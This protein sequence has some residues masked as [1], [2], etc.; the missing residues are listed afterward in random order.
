MAENVNNWDLRF[1]FNLTK[2]LQLRQHSGKAQSRMRSSAK[3]PLLLSAVIV[4][5]SLLPACQLPA[6]T[7]TTLY[8]FPALVPGTLNPVSGVQTG[9]NTDGAVPYAGLVLSGNTLYGTTGLGGTSSNGTVF[10][11]NTDGTGF[12]N[13]HTFATNYPGPN[14]HSIFGASN[15][16][17]AFPYGGLTL[18][19][20]TLYG[21]A[22]YGGSTGNGVVYKINT[23][24]TGFTNLHSFAGGSG[25]VDPLGGLTV[26]GSVLY[27]TTSEGGTSNGGTVFTLNTNGTGF[28][29]LAGVG[30]GPWATL[31]LSGNV[32]YGTGQIGGTSG[33]GVVFAVTTGGTGLTNLH[34][35]SATSGADSVNGDG[36]YPIAGLILSGNILYGT[37]EFGGKNGYGTVFAIN[38]NGT[39]FTNLHNFTSGSDGSI[40]EAGLLL[41]GGILYGTAS[42]GGMGGRGAIFAVSTNGAGFTTLNSFPAAESPRYT[43]SGGVFPNAGLILSGYTPY[44]TAESGGASGNGTVFSLSFAPQLAVALSG[45]NVILTWPAAFDGFSYAGF[46]LQSAGSLNPPASWTQ[47]V[48]GPVINGGQ[49][50]VNNPIFGTQQFYQLSQ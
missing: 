18:S 6:Q 34:S 35:F 4:S 44:G 31:I 33:N 41:S 45:T 14:N 49:Y 47:V 13:L 2:P 23:D 43:N 38:T 15:S 29:T 24:G 48:P 16:D 3:N 30:A 37:A 36:A 8:S 12:T 11:V 19:G 26:S 46:T 20:N 32:L 39:G 27:G 28:V 42:G 17:G 40:P 25:G 5:L 21:T 7:F 22:E 10:A 1:N 50:A 9:T